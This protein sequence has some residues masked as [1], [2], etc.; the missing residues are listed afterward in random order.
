[1]VAG[2]AIF[3]LLFVGLGLLAL[4]SMLSQRPTNTSEPDSLP[5]IAFDDGAFDDEKAVQSAHRKTT[6]DSE[7]R[8]AATTAVD[9]VSRSDVAHRLLAETAGRPDYRPPT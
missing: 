7:T 5:D 8:F 3:G 1:M 4:D 6:T 2:L 9:G